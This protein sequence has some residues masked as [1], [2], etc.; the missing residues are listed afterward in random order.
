MAT[1]VPKDDDVEQQLTKLMSQQSGLMKQ[2][3]TQGLSS[4]QAI[5]LGNSTAGIKA[6]QAAAYNAAV[7]LASQAASQA[8]QTGLQTA[9]FGQQ[10][11]L[12]KSQFG[13]ETGM[14]QAG[15]QHAATQAELERA[16]QIASLREQGYL[17]RLQTVTAG[18]VERGNMA[19]QQ[20]HEA[21]MAAQDRASR[22]WLA[23]VE[24]SNANKE[25]ASAS[26]AATNQSYSA[27][28][29]QI[30][31]NPELPANVRN[32]MLQHLENLRAYNTNLTRSLFQNF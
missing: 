3:R 28:V 10:T 31:S 22:E 29:A 8:H 18:E 27:S 20:A 12:Q 7:P 24:M 23:N 9:Q 1:V 2:A 14:Q 21:N 26:L 15:F 25:R 6:A 16:Q 30:M 17:Q 5:G 19:F 4:A 11:E 32:D 13:H